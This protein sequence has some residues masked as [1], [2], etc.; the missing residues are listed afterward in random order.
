MMFN[1]ARNEVMHP[2]EKRKA[3][4]PDGRTSYALALKKGAIVP[5][6]VTKEDAN[7]YVR[8]FCHIID[9]SGGESPRKA[10]KVSRNNSIAKMSQRIREQRRWRA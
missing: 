1:Q 7:R 4:D 9:L 3:L 5:H 8:Y 6:K 2:I 10:E